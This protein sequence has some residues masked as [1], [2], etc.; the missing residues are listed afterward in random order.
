MRRASL[1]VVGGHRHRAIGGVVLGS[2][3]QLLRVSPI[4]V[5]VFRQLA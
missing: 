1:I 3:A 2:A 4:S 5:L